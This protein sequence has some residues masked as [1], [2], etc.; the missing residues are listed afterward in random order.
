MS[1]TSRAVVAAIISAIE[2][3]DGDE[4]DSDYTY[5]LTA[6]GQVRY[7]H[8]PTQ[9]SRVPCVLVHDVAVS[10]TIAGGVPLGKYRRDLTVLCSGYVGADSDT[11]GARAFAALDLC[12]DIAR[13][14]EAD[15]QLGGLVYD[16]VVV[17]TPI[18]GESLGITGL[19]V[20]AIEVS[21]WWETT[22]G[23]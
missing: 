8:E 20:C 17:T 7:H 9:P 13:A 11:P 10:S 22:T 12:D 15:R 19:G 23:V 14:I 5:D 18:E 3:I 6:T 1:S 16:A 21:A 4:V 2:S